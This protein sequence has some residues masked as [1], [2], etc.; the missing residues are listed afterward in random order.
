MSTERPVKLKKRQ[1][2]A[3]PS[4]VED[5][6][7]DAETLKAEV[8]SFAAQL[9]LAAPDG[10]QV[11]FDDRDFRPDAASRSLDKAAKVT[12]SNPQRPA[13]LTKPA[14]PLTAIKSGS[15]K[16]QRTDARGQADQ[17]QFAKHSLQQPSKTAVQ[18][19]QTAALSAAH[20][21]HSASDLRPG[22]ITEHLE[23]MH[24]LQEAVCSSWTWKAHAT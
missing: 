6:P 9:G 1:A 20:L 16:K 17:K 24:L 3:K 13:A 11:G 14:V 21:T 2:S 22:A 8:R 10:D 23:T 19:P 7:A 12:T 18:T 15:R 4:L 5:S